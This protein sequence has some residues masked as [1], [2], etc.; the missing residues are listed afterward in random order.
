MVIKFLQGKS[1]Y[2]RRRIAI[3]WTGIVGIILIT[4]FI[5]VYTHPQPLRRD[6][7]RT[8]D[9]TYTIFLNKVQSL[10]HHT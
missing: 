6:P 7:E 5:L 8:I 9:S 4:I 3:I 1:L 2:V 10:F